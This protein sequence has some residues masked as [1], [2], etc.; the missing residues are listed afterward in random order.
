MNYIFLLLLFVFIILF[1]QKKQRNKEN[2]TSQYAVDAYEYTGH[3]RDGNDLLDDSLF[4]NVITYENDDN[5]YENGAMLGIDKCAGQ[6]K[7]K[8][9]EFGVTGVGYCFPPN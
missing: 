6:C 3:R 8:C 2:F 9:V 7:G 5:L 4:A 1:F